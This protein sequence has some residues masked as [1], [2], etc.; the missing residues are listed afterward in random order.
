MF[1]CMCER[2]FNVDNYPLFLE[3]SINYL[4][5]HIWGQRLM[6]WHCR[7]EKRPHRPVAGLRE[8]PEAAPEATFICSGA[9]W[10][11]AIE[12]VY[13]GQPASL[14]TSFLFLDLHEPKP[15]CE[16]ARGLERVED[17]TGIRVG[18]E[19]WYSSLDPGP[20]FSLALLLL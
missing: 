18:E 6:Q 4:M 13:P 17:G 8:G 19:W 20:P 1:C 7:A 9:F 14:E 15:P 10:G 2:L 11:P 3:T 16:L 12:E 5:N